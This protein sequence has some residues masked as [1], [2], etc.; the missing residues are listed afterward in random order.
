LNHSNICT[1]YD[2]GEQGGQAFVAMEF[3]DGMT[4]KHRI[5]GSPLE[6]EAPGRQ[7]THFP[8]EHIP[9][10]GWSPDAKKLLVARDHV[11]SDVV[12]LRDSK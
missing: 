8:T 9:V 1:I 10:F 7:I 3:L 2:I 6:T 11:E 5:N 4:L 12:L